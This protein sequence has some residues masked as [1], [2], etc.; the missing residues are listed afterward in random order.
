MALAMAMPGLVLAT[1]GAAGGLLATAHDF[2]TTAGYLPTQQRPGSGTAGAVTAYPSANVVGLCA[3]CH[4]PHSAYST[5]LLWNHKASTNAS[6]GWTDTTTAGG[7]TFAT[8]NSA[9]YKGPTVKCLSCHDGTVAIG[10]VALFNQRG[11]AAASNGPW[12]TYKITDPIFLMGVGGSLN[13][14]HPVGMPY[15]YGQVKNTYNGIQTGP[16]VLLDQYVADPESLANTKIKL[17]NNAGPDINGGASAGISGIECSS[18]H[19]PHNKQTVDTLFL[20]GKIAG[21]TQAGVGPGYICV[22]CHIK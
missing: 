16:D 10:D 14:N 20:R 1:E 13:G 19:D 5:S 7:T 18:C 21:S 3:Y 12:N 11:T 17:Y 6:F 8:L 4:T 22:S 9:T 2:S 15:P